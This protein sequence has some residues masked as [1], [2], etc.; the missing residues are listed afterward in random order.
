MVKELALTRDIVLVPISASDFAQ[1]GDAFA[2]YAS[3][4]LPGGS[5]HKVDE[6]VETLAV[7]NMVVINAAMPNALAFRLLCVLYQERPA[8]EKIVGVASYTTIANATKL[9]AV[10]LHPGALDYLAQAAEHG[11][12]GVS[13]DG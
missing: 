13:C 7:W 2:A 4:T 3:A 11:A 8:L 6:P 5:Y 10:P 12:D 9:A 1:L